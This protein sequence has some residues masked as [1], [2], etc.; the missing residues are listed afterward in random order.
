VIKRI[1][2]PLALFVAALGMPLDLEAQVAG[3]I[4]GYVRDESGAVI[5]GADVKATMIGQQ[6]SRS[7]IT[8]ETGFFNLLAM[9]RGV[10]Q[11]TAQLTGFA[12]QQ[13]KAEL[14]SGENL[15]V[16]FKM[17]LGQLSETVVVSGTAALT[18]SG[19][20]DDRRVQELPLNGRNV[21]ELA[22]TI[23]GI[24]D[25]QASEE[26]G[27]TRGGPTMIV[28]G[29]SRGQNNFTLNGSNFTNYSQTAGFNP[30]PPDAVQEIR[31]QTSAFSAEFGNNAG[32][33]VA[34]TSSTG[35]PGN[36]IGT[37]S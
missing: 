8:D 20:V 26:M 32:A 30:P 3:T 19:L 11:I 14:T 34:A 18:M 4:S 7:A 36:S 10:Y 23:P 35:R 31:V 13:T 22:S 28:H 17:N 37:P 9:P 33:Q 6:L 29:A 12:T 16:D 21:V 1:A 24:T 27:S 15:R 2:V 25:V 5:P